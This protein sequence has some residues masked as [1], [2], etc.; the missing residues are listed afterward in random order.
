MEDFVDQFGTPLNVGDRV[1]RTQIDRGAPAW[2]TTGTIVALRRT[3][4]GIR[5][6]YRGYGP[7]EFH[8]TRPEN[9]R[10]VRT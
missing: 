5:W 7:G 3:R 10:K 1:I 4:I 8:T 9:V 6:H 2:A